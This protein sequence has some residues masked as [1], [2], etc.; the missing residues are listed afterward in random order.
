M[1]KIKIYQITNELK[2]KGIELD[3]KTVLAFLESKGITGKTHSSSVEEEDAEMIRKHFDSGKPKAAEK[4]EEKKAAPKSE[5]AKPAAKKPAPQKSEEAKP[6]AAKPAAEKAAA[7]RPA[8]GKVPVKKKKSNIIF[9]INT[10]GNKGGARQVGQISR[11]RIDEPGQQ[12][13]GIIKPK[14]KP[15]PAPEVNII[16]PNAQPH[17]PQKPKAEG[18]PKPVEQAAPSGQVQTPAPAPAPTQQRSTNFGS[19]QGAKEA[20]INTGNAPYRNENQG[21]SRHP[22]APGNNR[23]GFQVAQRP[24]GKA[25]NQGKGK[26]FDEQKR[27]SEGDR[28]RLPDQR[29]RRDKGILVTDEEKERKRSRSSRSPIPSRSRNWQII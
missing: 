28:R 11:G 4:T 7:A 8:D 25:A 10:G 21:V 15:S 24:G 16:R 18:T 9:S 6:A 14:V 17:T 12:N 26:D 20:H 23:G 3:N 2:E 13:R 27:R 22:G 29:R 1:A 19:R 5:E